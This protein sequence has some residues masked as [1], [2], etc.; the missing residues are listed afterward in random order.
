MGLTSDQERI[1]TLLT[2]TITLLCKNGLHFRSEFSIEGLLGITLDQEN[3]FLISIKET[4]RTESPLV[5]LHAA[6][7]A[8]CTTIATINEVPPQK[9]DGGIRQQQTHYPAIAVVDSRRTSEEETVERQPVVS[10][11]PSLCK[12]VEGS[13]CKRV[14][15]K[16]RNLSMSRSSSCSDFSVERDYNVQGVEGHE[17]SASDMN[18]L[19]SS[20]QA[21]VKQCLRDDNSLHQGV[22]STPPACKQSRLHFDNNTA[23]DAGN[24]NNEGCADNTSFDVINIKE[25]SD[26]ETESSVISAQTSFMVNYQHSDLR[27]SQAAANREEYGQFFGSQTG[28]ASWNNGQNQSGSFNSHQVNILCFQLILLFI[29]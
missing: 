10:A 25:E 26:D 16:K 3:V 27:T 5:R 21:D 12:E 18:S 29:A 23:R 22:M 20:H 1:K 14:S 2:E 7:K 6:P 15:G 28:C 4:I 9:T 19:N 13:M 17:N 24:A 8:S 11:V